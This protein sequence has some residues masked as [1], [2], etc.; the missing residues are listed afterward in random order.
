VASSD[1]SRTVLDESLTGDEITAIAE[2][3]YVFSVPMLAVYRYVCGTFLVPSLPWYKAWLNTFAGERKTRLP[4]Q[5]CDLTE[6]GHAVLVGG[7]GSARERKLRG[8][9]VMNGDKNLG[10]ARLLFGDA[11]IAFLLLNEVRH[12]I[13]ARVF[14]VSREDSNVVTIIAVG[15]LA[16]GLHGSAARVRAVPA[17]LSVAEAAIGAAALKE[18]AH[19]V[20]GD[21]S[22]TT[23][24][25]GALVAFAVLGRSFGPVLRGSFRGVQGSIRGVIAWSRRFLAF[26]GGR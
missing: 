17:R 2:A 20:A 1:D 5:G 24:F 9:T 12:R 16:E 8:G 10:A 14:G 21:W 4:L 23:P 7:A 3:A 26:L 18:T 6:C 19:S 22:R 13:V 25:F 11:I 15:S